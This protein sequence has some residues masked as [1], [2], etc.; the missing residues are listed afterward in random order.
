M[1]QIVDARTDREA[2]SNQLP[3]PGERPPLVNMPVRGR[4]LLD[5]L[6]QFPMLIRGQQRRAPAA[7][8]AEIPPASKAWRHR[9]ADIFVTRNRR[10]TRSSLSPATMYS[11]AAKRTCS[12]RALAAASSPP[13][14]AYL[15]HKA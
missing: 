13:P 8:S 6:D 15:T 14:C 1:A 12:C 4:A 9:L 2:F 11:T 10:A 3:D 5:Q 7:P